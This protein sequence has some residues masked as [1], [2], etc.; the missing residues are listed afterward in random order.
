[1]IQFATKEYLGQLKELWAKTFGDT[2]Q[3]IDLY[4][5]EGCRLSDVLADVEGGRLCAMASLL[6]LRLDWG[7]KT[8]E[9][10]YVYAVA[11]DETER[12]KGRSTRLLER[13]HAVMQEQGVAASVLVPASESLF[14][15]YERRGYRRAFRLNRR[16]VSAAE[17][18]KNTAPPHE[19]SSCGAERYYQLRNFAFSGCAPFAAW[20]EPQL[21]FA[22]QLARLYGAQIFHIRTD[23][24]EAAAYCIRRQ[25]TVAVKEIAAQGLDDACVLSVLHAHLGAQRYEVCAPARGGGGT[26]F[27]F[28]MLHPLSPD[29]LPA[30]VPGAPAYFNLAMD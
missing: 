23:A 12:G 6:P 15:F 22:M 26:A 27:D 2:R 5:Q 20:G 18:I 8:L 1:M 28:A 25:G 21:R 13:A 17:L 16:S 10:R 4:F 11:T 9:G 19:L 7:G 29:A 14:S 24:G 30:P 3:A